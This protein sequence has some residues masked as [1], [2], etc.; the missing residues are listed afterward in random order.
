MQVADPSDAPGEGGAA[1]G[2]TGFTA[3]TQHWKGVECRKSSMAHL[4]VQLATLPTLG[5]NAEAYGFVFYVRQLTE[6]DPT[7]SFHMVNYFVS[8]STV[9]YVDAQQ[10]TVKPMPAHHD[11]EGSP[12]QQ[13]IFYLPL[14]PTDAGPVKMEIV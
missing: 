5:P 13:Q 9:F 11:P 7:P 8:Q 12:Y 3:V 10:G 14:A 6:E 4:S 2:D 1:A